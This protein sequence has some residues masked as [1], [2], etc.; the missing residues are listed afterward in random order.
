M[1][2][3]H[4]YFKVLSLLQR[5][6][7]YWWICSIN[8]VHICNLGL[9]ILCPLPIWL[10]SHGTSRFSS[11]PET[12]SLSLSLSQNDNHC[13]QSPPTC[14]FST[15]FGLSAEILSCFYS[16]P[17]LARARTLKT[18]SLLTNIIAYLETQVEEDKRGWDL[19]L[20][21]SVMPC[22]CLAYPNVCNYTW[23]S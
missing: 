6:L 14:F 11:N 9:S 13:T 22:S 16:W 1:H 21:S 7:I 17:L 12:Y 23:A 8:H 4:H 3:H 19:G 18:L 20:A 15:F 2:I 5:R 10:Y